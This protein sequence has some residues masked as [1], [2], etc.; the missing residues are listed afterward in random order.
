MFA[1]GEQ[2]DVDIAGLA[3]LPADI[4]AAALKV[5]VT[6]TSAAGFW[7]VF[8]TGSDRPRASN[9]NVDGPGQTIANQVLARL[10]S[11]RLTVF[12]QS[13]GHLVIDLVGWFTGPS[14]PAAEVGLFVP[15]SPSRL[16]D[17]RQAPLGAL[18]GHN[19]TVE[20]AVANRF[21]VPATGVGAV[22]VNATITQSSGAGFFSL[23]PARNYRPLASSLNASRVNQTIANHVITPVST[24][25][26]AFYTQNGAHL[27]ADITGWYTGAEQAAVLPPHVP[28]TGAGG[29]TPQGNYAFQRVVNGGPLRWDPCQPIRYVVNLG[30]YPE[31]SR[32]VIAE[33]VERLEATTGLVLIP[34]GDTTFMPRSSEPSPIDPADGAFRR[35]PFEV[36]IALTDSN[37]TD[38]VGGSIAGLSQSSGYGRGQGVAIAVSSVVID[39]GD[40]GQ[41]P[42]WASNGAGAVLL[43]E[44]AHLAGLTHV[45]DTTQL[46]NPFATPT[47]PNS[48]GAGDLTGLWQLGIRCRMRDDLGPRSAVGG[49]LDVEQLGVQAA[50]GDQLLVGADLDHARAV[51]HHDQV[52]HPHRREP[53]RHQHRHPA[54]VGMRSWRLGEPLEQRM[55]GLGVERGGGFVEDQQQ[56]GVTHEPAGQCQ[57]LPL[58]EADLGALVPRRTELGVESV[59]QALDHV[60]GSGPIDR[61]LGWPVG[62]RPAADRRRRRSAGRGTRTGRSPGTPPPGTTATASVAIVGQVDAV[63]GDPSR[64]GAYIRASSLTSVD[65]PAPFSPTTA[66]TVPAGRCTMTS[67]S[68]SRSVPG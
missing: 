39:M 6:E 59:C 66:T 15:V 17:S 44:L 8:P 54:G 22:V 43:H 33:A 32:R 42:E 68:T 48:Y 49:G 9:L 47:G 14:A 45:N 28:L 37:Q 56:R 64:V 46:M 26:F 67:S 23:T 36:V 25:G 1:A 34:A 58:A 62:P 35:G 51:H 7:T 20:V 3:G 41:R 18:P 52:G 24:A 31:S 57:L 10:S 12:S 55:L 19:R 16:L 53:V 11:G 65:L 2:I 5:T 21:G 27:V 30:G 60:L 4:T 38:L 50:T 61:A 40:V 29:P 13:G 63:D